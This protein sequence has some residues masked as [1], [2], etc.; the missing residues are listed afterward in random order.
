MDSEQ[1]EKSRLTST[2]IKFLVRIGGKPEWTKLEMK[3]SE[4]I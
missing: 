4:R 3:H 2:E 1:R